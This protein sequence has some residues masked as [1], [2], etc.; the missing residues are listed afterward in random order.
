MLVVAS[1]ITSLA[2]RAIAVRQGCVGGC[3][4]M[5]AAACAS[6]GAAVV[7]LAGLFVAVECQNTHVQEDSGT[8]ETDCLGYKF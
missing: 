3:F 8:A 7:L 4:W 2:V 5:S 1:N 6:V